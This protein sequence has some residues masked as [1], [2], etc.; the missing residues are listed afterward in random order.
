MKRGAIDFLGIYLVIVCVWAFFVFGCA[1]QPSIPVETNPET[2]VIETPK[3]IEY[4]AHWDGKKRK[5]INGACC[6]LVP[7]KVYTSYLVD[8]MEKYGNDLLLSNPKDAE[9]Y[10][11]GYGKKTRQE[12]IHMWVMIFS[13]LSEFESG[14]K[15]WTSYYEKNVA[16]NPTSRGLFQMSKASANG[17]YFCGI[18][19]EMDL[20]DP[21]V[22][23]ECLVKAANILVPEGNKYKSTPKKYRLASYIG[24]QNIGSVWQGLGAYWSPFRR[25]EQLNKI[26]AAAKS[27]CN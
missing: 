7:S 13:Q 25:I 27:A 17:N 11:P 5:N 12:R 19:D 10:C 9:D 22:N 26:K 3:P 24:G 6:E 21:K 16:D 1:S 2:P 18:K 14:F 4:T 15:P 23:I 20:H 8:A